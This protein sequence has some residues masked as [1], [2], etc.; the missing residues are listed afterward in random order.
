MADVDLAA[1]PSRLAYAIAAQARRAPASPALREPDRGD[2]GYGDLWHAIESVAGQL[3]ALGV[4]PGDRVM[5]VGENCAN[6]VALIFATGLCDAWI[7]NVNARLS[8]REI[9]SIRE[10]SGARRVFYTADISPDAR[11]HGERDG[12]VPAQAPFGQWLVGAVNDD[13]APEP[14][15]ADGALQP[16][17]LIYTTGTTG[18]PKGVLLSHRTLLYVAT[19]SGRLRGLVPTDR[20]YG[21]LPIAHVYGL[22]S[23]M[24]GT[25][26]AG[27][28]LVLAPRFSAPALLR[29]LREERLTIL[30]GVP[31]MYA[32]VLEQLGPDASPL[33]NSLRFAYAGG[34]PLTPGLKA[35]V[36]RL[37]GVALHNGYGMTESGPTICQT[38]LAAPRNDTSVGHPIPGVAVRVVDAAGADVPV[39]EPGEIRVR[40]P[41]V[42]LGYYRDPALTA[43]T[44][45][46]GGWLNT[47]DMGRLGPDGALFI[48]GRTKELIIRSG[49]NV[50]PL[51]VE[52]VLNAHPA[53][54]QSAVV[55]RTCGDGNEEVIA[56]VEAAP[57]HAADPAALV[58]ELTTYL[59]GALAPYKCPAHIVVLPALP[60]AATGKILKGR[61][62]DL[63]MQPL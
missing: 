34:S 2:I 29:A 62:R 54:T 44:M 6:L 45:H 59:G 56:F 30:Q 38:D 32:R 21:V 14:V 39:G 17:A 28:C 49:F 1:L 37:L 3:R 16:A 5:A 60:A 41:N 33:P 13:C 53:V 61:L 24:L 35:A 47:G 48:V 23:V 46:P 7:V 22:A 15:H 20:A 57:R 9:A 40:G 58:A 43:A 27:A 18:Q 31:A 52:T 63:A 25:L 4:R 10:H 26:N 12:A 51:E 8:A 19:V 50:Y 11:A 42:M 55:G 36:E